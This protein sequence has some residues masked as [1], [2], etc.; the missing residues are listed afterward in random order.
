M[1]EEHWVLGISLVGGMVILAFLLGF[2][3]SNSQNEPHRVV[4]GAVCGADELA[5]PFY[6]T[7]CAE[8][9]SACGSGCSVW[10]EVQDD[11]GAQ[12][13]SGIPGFS[14]IPEQVPPDIEAPANI[15][16]VAA[17]QHTATPNPFS[18]AG[19]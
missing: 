5:Q 9:K 17:D 16:T 13:W 3:L 2:M 18:L 10:D 11:I 8:A 12:D 7:A 19:E 4:S 6:A 15:A 14:D 1:K